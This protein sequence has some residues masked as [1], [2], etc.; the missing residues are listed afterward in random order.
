[1][2]LPLHLLVSVHFD[3]SRSADLAGC[4]SVGG[5]PS[6]SDGLPDG[7]AHLKSQ[8]VNLEAI[9]GE[10]LMSPNDTTNSD[11]LGILDLDAMH[12]NEEWVCPMHCG[13]VHLK[14][15]LSLSA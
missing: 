14:Y 6:R 10:T 2:Y 9:K 12:G 13:C 15:C 1:M 4:L 8:D 3:L 5:A 11:S 7:S